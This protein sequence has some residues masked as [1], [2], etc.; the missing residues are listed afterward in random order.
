MSHVLDG[1]PV[2]PM[3][4]W[5]EVEKPSAKAQ[6]AAKPAP[7]GKQKPEKKGFRL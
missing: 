7:T 1:T 2:D 5:E 6:E 3:S 4:I